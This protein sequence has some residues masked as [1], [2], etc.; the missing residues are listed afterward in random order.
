MGDF[1]GFRVSECR[2][3]GLRALGREQGQSD[4]ILGSLGGCSGRC[5]R[6]LLDF[7]CKVDQLSSL[8]QVIAF[9]QDG[10]QK[11]SRAGTQQRGETN[12]STLNPETQ[13]PLVTQCI[14]PGTVPRTRSYCWACVCETLGVQGYQGFV[15]FSFT[16][17]G[18]SWICVRGLGRPRVALRKKVAGH[19]P[20]CRH[21]LKKLQGC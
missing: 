15:V 9:G 10:Y 3:Y 20:F 14:L 19:L 21:R 2:V 1:S 7:D 16:A 17:L 6:D 4:K 11:H 18:F 12:P 8:I 13:D 5:V